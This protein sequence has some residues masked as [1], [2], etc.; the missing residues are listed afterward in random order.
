MNGGMNMK[1]VKSC[2]TCYYATKHYCSKCIIKPC[3]G[4]ACAKVS[5]CTDCNDTYRNYQPVDT[6]TEG[7]NKLPFFF[8][9][10]LSVFF[11]IQIRYPLFLF[12][13]YKVNVL[14][15]QIAE[16]AEVGGGL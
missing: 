2:S 9:Y 10:I 7:A 4:E 3:I 14:Y 5:T 1:S 6:V 8:I 15:A 11:I 13:Y 16:V 12:I